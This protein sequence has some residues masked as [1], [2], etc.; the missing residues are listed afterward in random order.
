MPHYPSQIEFSEKYYDEVYEYRHVS[1]PKEVYKKIKTKEC[2]TEEEWRALG[3]IQS[4][5]WE[6]YCRYWG[7]PYILLFRRPIGTDPTNGTI[8]DAIK[9][10][11]AEFEKKRAI[12]LNKVNPD[13]KYEDYI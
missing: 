4:K 10:K 9:T 6:N 1:L 3:I 13:I 5:G 8:T 12:H 2:L 7:E 11:V